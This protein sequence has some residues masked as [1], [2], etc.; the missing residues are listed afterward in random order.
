MPTTTSPLPPALHGVD[1]VLATTG[2]D[3]TLFCNTSGSADLQ[4]SW[5]RSF[6]NGSMLFPDF[7]EE[8]DE[9]VRG[10]NTSTLTI[11][12][13]GTV[14]A[15][16]YKCCVSFDGELLGVITGELTTQSESSTL[17]STYSTRHPP[18][19]LCYS[20]MCGM[21]ASQ[22]VLSCVSMWYNVAFN[23]ASVQHEC[24][25]SPNVNTMPMAPLSSI[26]ACRDGAESIPAICI[27]APRENFRPHRTRRIQDC[28]GQ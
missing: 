17:I 5:T 3:A 26:Y 24:L 21:L 27:F 20:T 10:A 16:D 28:P 9:R 12:N 22:L 11:L 14:D 4:Y 1:D 7:L 19:F 18:L 25:H 23:E 6:E 13:V 2:T 8:Q 15:M